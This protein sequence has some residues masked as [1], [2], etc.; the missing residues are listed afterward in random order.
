MVPVI[1]TVVR[2]KDGFR[3]GTGTENEL[4]LVHVTWP[5]PWWEAYVRLPIFSEKPDEV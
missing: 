3:V 2:R 1:K 5:W 4:T